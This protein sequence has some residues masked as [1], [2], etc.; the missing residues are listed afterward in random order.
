VRVRY[1]VD[2]DGHKAGDECVVSPEVGCRLQCETVVDIIER[3]QDRGP[4][5]KMKAPPKGV[6]DA[7]R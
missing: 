5:S 6:D 1:R 4:T 7:G 2:F 3:A